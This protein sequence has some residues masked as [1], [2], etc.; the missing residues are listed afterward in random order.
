[1]ALRMVDD[2]NEQDD[3]VQDSNNTGGNSGGGGGF[4]IGGLLS[5]LPLVLGLFKG[6]G[7]GQPA[8]G[9]GRAGC[10]G[11]SILLLLAIGA[12]AYFVFSK[13]GCNLLHKAQATTNSNFS[14]TGYNFNADET[15]K[16]QVYEGLE[17][18]N[19]KNP[20]PEAVSLAA[21][22][23]PRQNQGKQG[24]CVAW[25]SAYA[26]RT[27]LEAASTR[28]DPTQVAY[29]PAFLYNNIALEDCQGSYIQKAM[30][31]MQKYGSVNYRDFQY[32]EN[33]CSRA[34][35]QSLIEKAQ[36]GRILGFHRLTET[37]D[38]NGINIRAIKE[39]L[40]KDAPV[41]IGMMVGGSFLEGMI[42]KKVW[43]PTGRDES[44][45]GFGG[46]AMCVIGYNDRI[47]GGAFEIMNSWGPEWGQN[48]IG[49]VRYADFV[50]YA[51][52]AYGLD[53]LPKRGA[54]LNVAFECNVGLFNPQTR[55]NVPLK[56]AG[57]N[58]FKTVAPIKKGSTFKIELKNAV[59]CYIYIFTPDQ[60][61]KSSVLFPYNASHSP[62]C[63]I[64]GFR[65]FPRRQSIMADEVGNKEYMGVVV[66]KKELN[67]DA[68]NNAINASP[69]TDF[70]GK[71]GD[72]IAGQT[73][74]NVQYGNTQNGMM[75]FKSSANDGKSIISCLVE[76]DKN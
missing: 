40:A 36:Q 51:R 15:R 49:F 34:A 75:Y 71:L 8:G 41:V 16:A 45:T 18:D 62:Y 60:T 68:I 54:A 63:G 64:T 30:E 55:S 42:G 23:P 76:I 9:G 59:E 52:E 2:N 53:P 73:I 27:I 24:S 33:D 5:F 72:A 1:M 6:R 21:F 26:A 31:F 10:S 61:G 67:Y 44:Q 19:K 14:E 70:A 38:V 32:D 13:S 12:I 48:G 74:G 29:S 22:A 11:K 43:R 3:Y 39:H 20:L 46:H 56:Y 4:N 47:E 65:L 58:L 7:G 66:S 69:K 17:D 28:Q 37:D 57:S 25:S 35:N 50:T